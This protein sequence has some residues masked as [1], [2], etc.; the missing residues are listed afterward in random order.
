MARLLYGH[1]P[2]AV[3]VSVDGADF[4][5]GITLSPT[6]QTAVPAV[7]QTVRDILAHGATAL[8]APVAAISH[9]RPIGG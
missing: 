5:Y 8:S 7:V 9:R 3:I 6:V 2:T 4:G 1:C